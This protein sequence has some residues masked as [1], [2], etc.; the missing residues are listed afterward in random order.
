MWG[1]LTNDD[2]TNDDVTVTSYP[3][4]TIK[5]YKLH[6]KYNSPLS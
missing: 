5:P 3:K 4:S 2:V 6:Y 1:E